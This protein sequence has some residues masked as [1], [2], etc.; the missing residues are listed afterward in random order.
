MF[1]FSRTRP[2]EYIR[3]SRS[4]KYFSFL[5]LPEHVVVR[6]QVTA[7]MCKAASPSLTGSSEVIFVTTSKTCKNVSLVEL[8]SLIE[9][10][11]KAAPLEVPGEQSLRSNFQV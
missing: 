5:Y 11:P 1:L 4:Q 8:L 7:L 3:R 2:K 10:V 9:S 6:E